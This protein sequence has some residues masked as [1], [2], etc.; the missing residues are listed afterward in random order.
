MAVSLKAV[1]CI[2]GRKIVFPQTFLSELSWVI[3]KSK[4]LSFCKYVKIFFFR[5]Q[6]NH[7]PKKH[8]FQ[9]CKDRKLPKLRSSLL[10]DHQTQQ[11]NVFPQTFLS[12]LSWVISKSKDLSF[13]KY[14]KIFF[15]RAQNNHSPKKHKF[16]CCKDRKLPKLG[17]SLLK[18]HQTQQKNVMIPTSSEYTSRLRFHLTLLE[19]SDRDMI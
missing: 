15:F 16:Q 1:H 2:S 13:C 11:K 3:S 10:K 6:N 14:V 4:D 8:K 9:C 17:S 7:S 5:A 18:D 19:Y 12:E